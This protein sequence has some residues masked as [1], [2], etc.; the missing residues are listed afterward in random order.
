MSFPVTNDGRGL[1]PLDRY[2]LPEASPPE[3]RLVYKDCYTEVLEECEKRFTSCLLS[4]IKHVYSVS[5]RLFAFLTAS[6]TEQHARDVENQGQTYV[7][8]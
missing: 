1:D 7:M 8:S 3:C 2:G 6:S 4:S 5:R